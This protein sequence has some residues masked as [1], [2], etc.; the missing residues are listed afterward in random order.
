MPSWQ[1]TSRIGCL[2]NNPARRA[3]GAP[4]VR[5]QWT[6]VPLD[7]RPRWRYVVD[8]AGAANAAPALKYKF[9]FTPHFGG[10][11]E[12]GIVPNKIHLFDKETEQAINIK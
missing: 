10:Y 5:L 11:T 9:Y 8:K 12:F 1:S 4:T 7:F 2:I 3:R 6:R